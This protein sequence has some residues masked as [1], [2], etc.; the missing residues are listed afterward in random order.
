MYIQ[1]AYTEI[2]AEELIA[3]LT[4]RDRQVKNYKKMEIKFDEV[5]SE[6]KKEYEKMEELQEQLKYYKSLKNIGNVYNETPSL[7]K[8]T[9]RQ[10][11]RMSVPSQS[12]YLLNFSLRD[13]EDGGQ[14]RSKEQ[15]MR[16]SHYLT[17]SKELATIHKNQTGKVPTR[18]K[19]KIETED[20]VKGKSAMGNEYPIE[21]IEYINMYLSINPIETWSELPDG[22]TYNSINENQINC[23]WCNKIINSQSLKRH[24]KS[25]THIKKVNI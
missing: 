22:F 23:N 3:I 20:I 12:H 19:G 25:K 14:Y 8:K 9:F 11:I 24:L 18:F 5:K 7:N 16:Y 10:L 4:R 17:L 13:T 1:M 15:K 6:L 2:S 21:Y